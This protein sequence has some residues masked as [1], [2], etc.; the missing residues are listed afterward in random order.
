MRLILL[1][2]IAAAGAAFVLL[3]FW[4]GSYTA[5]TQEAPLARIEMTT[6]GP[7]R[8]ELDVHFQSGARETF[9]MAGDYF[10]MEA[11]VLTLKNWAT[12]MGEAPRARLTKLRGQYHQILE[13]AVSE[14]PEGEA[15]AVTSLPCRTD[16]D[17]SDAQYAVEIAPVETLVAKLGAWFSASAGAERKPFYSAAGVDMAAGVVWIC[18]TEDALVARPGDFGCGG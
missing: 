7:Q 3:Q 6:L 5:L 17:V 8:H 11:E 12:V 18:M 13:G 10:M 4:L 15:F 14:C 9:R 2:A 16:Y 1:F